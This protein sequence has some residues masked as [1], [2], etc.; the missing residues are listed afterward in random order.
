MWSLSYGGNS[1]VMPA[2]QAEESS[3]TFHSGSAGR[4]NRCFQALPEDKMANRAGWRF[5]ASFL[6]LSLIIGPAA[7]AAAENSGQESLRKQ[8]RTRNPIFRRGC[9]A[10]AA[11]RK[12]L[13]RPMPPRQPTT[14]RRKANPR[15]PD[16]N[17]IK[18]KAR[19]EPRYGGPT[20]TDRRLIF[21]GGF[22]GFLGR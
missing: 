12:Q 16:N 14:P 4:S 7:F 2:R 19:A 10:K 1:F 20:G 8:S 15:R 17:A 6:V 22:V 11:A 18:R 3:Y 5:G 9:R 13:R 21:I